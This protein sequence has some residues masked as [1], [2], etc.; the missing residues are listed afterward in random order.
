MTSAARK[1]DVR[2]RRN[3][4]VLLRCAVIS[5]MHTRPFAKSYRDVVTP[6]P[7]PFCTPFRRSVR[8]LLPR[9]CS[10]S[11]KM[12]NHCRIACGR[13]ACFDNISRVFIL[14]YVI[15][16]ISMLVINYSLSSFITNFSRLEIKQVCLRSSPREKRNVKTR[17]R[18]W[19]VLNFRT[20]ETLIFIRYV[21]SFYA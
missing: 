3:A 14:Q 5:G 12:I 1:S 8:L 20:F 21:A 17:W 6:G 16:K 2:E 11:S 15:K 7:R 13:I 18:R 19:R 4:N 10:L 9:I